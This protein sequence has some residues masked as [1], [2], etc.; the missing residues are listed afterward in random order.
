MLDGRAPDD[1]CCRIKVTQKVEQLFGLMR[2]QTT[3]SETAP[4]ADAGNVRTGGTAPCSP[5]TTAR[6]QSLVEQGWRQ[7]N[8][9]PHKS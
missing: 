9:N 8:T 3:S 2:G 1:F 7:N 4:D 5:K 6:D